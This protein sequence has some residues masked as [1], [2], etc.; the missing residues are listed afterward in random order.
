MFY[1]IVLSSKIC[2]QNFDSNLSI[3]LHY[4]N[5]YVTVLF[6]KSANLVSKI[7]T[8]LHNLL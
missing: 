6:T 7:L 2:Q 3:T 4:V 5:R 1:C 8:F